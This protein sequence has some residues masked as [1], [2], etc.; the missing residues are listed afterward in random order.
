[1]LLARRTY[2]QVK[3][4]C[5]LC[6]TQHA[7]GYPN[8]FDGICAAFAISRYWP[9]V[10]HSQVPSLFVVGISSK[11]EVVS[12]TLAVLEAEIHGTELKIVKHWPLACEAGWQIM[13]ELHNSRL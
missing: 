3:K 11:K 13:S 9:F 1:M 4:H 5:S 10:A 12:M 7:A 2:S 8:F 6:K